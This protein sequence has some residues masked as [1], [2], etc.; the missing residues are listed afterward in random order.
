VHRARFARGVREHCLD[1]H[2]IFDACDD[3][4]RAAA[5]RAGLDVDAEHALQALCA[6]RIAA[7][8]SVGVRTSALATPSLP[9][10]RPAL[11]TN[12]RGVY[13]ALKAHGQFSQ[14]I[15]IEAV[16]FVGV[17]AGSTIVASLDDVPGD[18]GKAQADATGH[19][20]VLAKTERQRGYQE[21]VVCRL[22]PED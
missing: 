1:H 21:T 16:I 6:Q 3:A 8:R 9:L 15:E 13:C 11:V 5:A 18:A 12:A 14:V 20:D 10:P 2:R 17:E 4:H 7:R 19:D 22:F